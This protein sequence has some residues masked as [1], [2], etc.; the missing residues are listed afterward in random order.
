MWSVTYSEV[1]P[2]DDGVLILDHYKADRIFP[3]YDKWTDN[4]KT[5]Y[6][7]ARWCATD[8]LSSGALGEASENYFVGISGTE[9][10]V[11]ISI[12]RYR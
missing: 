7:E 3:P 9:V 8:L 10:D 4:I 2:D 12:S 5:L 11:N 6:N 1:T